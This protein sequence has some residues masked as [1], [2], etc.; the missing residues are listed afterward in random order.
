[1]YVHLDYRVSTSRYSYRKAMSAWRRKICTWWNAAFFANWTQRTYPQENDSLF[2]IYVGSPSFMLP[3][4]RRAPIA[5]NISANV[6]TSHQRKWP[7]WIGCFSFRQVK[8]LLKP[9]LFRI[10]LGPA[11]DI[12]IRLECLDF[13]RFCH[14]F[15]AILNIVVNVNFQS[16]TSKTHC[17]EGNRPTR[18]IRQPYRHWREKPWTIYGKINFT[19][20]LGTYADSTDSVT[21]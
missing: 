18:R 7:P 15:S 12:A 10:R 1:M 17:S 13:M 8:D 9:D 21:W 3:D 19:N 20:P 4:Q 16:F 6:M 2:G 14:I 11:T 5:H